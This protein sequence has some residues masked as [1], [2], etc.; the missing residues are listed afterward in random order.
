MGRDL[1][2]SQAS[3]TKTSMGM[4]CLIPVGQEFEHT[5]EKGGYVLL[6]DPYN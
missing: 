2:F 5:T 6:S 1:H 4:T 3:A